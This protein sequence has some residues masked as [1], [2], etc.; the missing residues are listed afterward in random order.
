[1]PDWMLEEDFLNF[2]PYFILFF[3]SI[4]IGLMMIFLREKPIDSVKDEN[5]TLV[6][7]IFKKSNVNIF[8]VRGYHGKPRVVT[9]KSYAD[10]H[11]YITHHL[12]EW[13]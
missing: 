6:F 2:L 4:M 8:R 11:Y 10:V 7:K 1:M 5:G 3:T 13:K 12:D 9:F